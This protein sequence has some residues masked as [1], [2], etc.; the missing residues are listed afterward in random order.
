[1]RKAMT[2]SEARLWSGL[3]AL[4][5]EGFQFR[6]QHPLHGFYPDFVCLTRRLIVEVDGD[7]HDLRGQHD[8]RR[9]AAMTKHGFKTVRVPAVALK[10]DADLVAAAILVELRARSHIW[11]GEPHPASPPARPP[12]P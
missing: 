4:R 10:D 1:M 3:K 9:D 11:K 12:S 5:A 2:P 8:V 6:R 7:S